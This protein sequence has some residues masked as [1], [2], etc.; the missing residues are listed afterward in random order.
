MTRLI[1]CVVLLAGCAAELPGVDAT[2]YAQSPS[3]DLSVRAEKARL[4]V[5]QTQDLIDLGIP[6]AVPVLD[7][8][9][10]LT[11]FRAEKMEGTGFGFPDYELRY[12]HETGTCL[13]VRGATEG[14]GDMFVM[15]PTGE[16]MADLTHI[17]NFGPV[18]LGWTTGEDVAEQFLDGESVYAEWFGA[19][20]VVYSITSATYED[21]CRRLEVDT[22]ARILQAIRY[23][24]P[25]DD[26]DGSNRFQYVD[27]HSMPVASATPAEAIERAFVVEGEFHTVEIATQRSHHAVGYIVWENLMDDSMQ[28]RRV[29]LA[30]VRSQNGWGI[31]EAGEQVRC[32]EGRGHILWDSTPCL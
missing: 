29:R 23:L 26:I 7:N 4:S 5:L 9:W 20:G 27:L 18:R 17:S 15:P 2:A 10:E 11:S 6:I 32:Y 25:Q 21:R 1:A 22:A 28:A 8:D 12:R 31:I 13:D 3:D 24:D 30:L 19:D 14:L 16:Q